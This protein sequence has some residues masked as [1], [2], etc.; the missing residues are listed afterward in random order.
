M[1]RRPRIPVPLWRRIT[2]CHRVIHKVIPEYHD[3]P[4]EELSMKW[5]EKI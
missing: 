3:T 5:W 2:N 4:D 1:T